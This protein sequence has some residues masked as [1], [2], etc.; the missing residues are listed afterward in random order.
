MIR[1]GDAAPA[2]IYVGDTPVARVY[3]GDTVVWERGRA[4][5][6]TLVLTSELT[7]SLYFTQSA[8]NGVT[9]D[10]GDG[11]EAETVADLAASAAHTYGE[12]GTYTVT[13]SAGSGVTWC[14]GCELSQKTYGLMGLYNKESVH[15][16]LTGF[17]FRQGCGL[18][19]EGAFQGCTGLTAISL[20]GWITQIPK[21]TF[22][23][24]TGITEIEI[25]ASVTQIGDSAFEGCS[26]AYVRIPETVYTVGGGAF[27]CGSYLRYAEVGAAELGPCVFFG[28]DEV[29]G[30]A[31]ALEK[32]W[33]RE[34]CTTLPGGD[35]VLNSAFSSCDNATIYAEVSERPA[36]W[37]ENFNYVDTKKDQSG[38][39]QPLYLPVIYGQTTRPW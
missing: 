21:Y 16:Q 2:A 25:P 1:I 29:A 26:L 14:P 35:N 9:I 8:A 39:T 7:Q 3:A 34:T 5:T 13:L 32:I 4:T 36:G 24:C 18:E 6:L 37:D 38:A 27:G 23:G 20:P 12:A 10:W 19:A 28:L 11:S 33:I 15:P 30:T 31:D 22:E 17:T